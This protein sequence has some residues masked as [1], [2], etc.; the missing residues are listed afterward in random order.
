MDTVQLFDKSNI[1]SL[2]WPETEEGRQARSLLKPMVKQG[3]NHFVDNINTQLCVLSINNTV[4]PLTINDNNYTNSYVCSPY[5]HYILYGLEYVSSLRNFFLRIPLTLLLKTMGKIFKSGNINKVV[6]V[7]NWL[8]STDL[9]PKLTEKE[10]CSIQNY[11]LHHFPDH[12]ILFRSIHK[13]NGNFLYDSLK[14]NRFQFIAS[15]QIFFLKPEDEAAFTSRAFKSDLKLLR[16]SSYCEVPEPQILNGEAS[17]I[18]ELY[19]KI[20]Q[21][22]HSTMN[23]QFNQNFINLMIENR[24]PHLIA[25]QKEGRIDAVAAYLYLNGVMLAPFLGYDT[26]VDKMEKLYRLTCTILAL[27]AKKRGLIFNL[28]AGA[29]FYK[30]IRKAEG[31]LECLAVYHRHLS[32]SRRIPWIVLRCVA[33]TI[34]VPIIRNYDK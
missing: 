27:E 21:D 22:R 34:G 14:K 28:S 16:E 33:N 32:F 31:I 29:S 19:T 6:I 24:F 12:A 30:S 8:F 1:D 4:M 25:M 26:S 15:R 7:N 18:K 9:Y 11:L 3:P 2:V 13:Y 10:I 5:G 17:R 20:Y 23:P